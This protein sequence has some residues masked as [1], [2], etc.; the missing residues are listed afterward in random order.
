MHAV[1]LATCSVTGELSVSV[2]AAL[3]V[4]WHFAPSSHC[5]FIFFV[6]VTLS[7]LCCM[8]ACR[9]C[10]GFAALEGTNTG[11]QQALAKMTARCTALE[12]GRQ[13]TFGSCCV[14]QLSP[15]LFCFVSCCCCSCRLLSF[16]R[17]FFLSFLLRF[18]ALSR[19]FHL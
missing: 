7:Y 8:F 14:L 17:S 12:N 13:T 5:V 15:M 19:A 9:S 2:C 1:L 6:C 10:A 16:V 18:R 4:V 3:F 11:H